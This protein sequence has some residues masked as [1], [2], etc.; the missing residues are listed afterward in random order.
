MKK[1]FF[2]T[3]IECVGAAKLCSI[4]LIIKF[5]NNDKNKRSAVDKSYFALGAVCHQFESGLPDKYVI[6]A[7]AQSGRAT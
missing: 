4:K 5:F 3:Q 2:T 7:V 6:H 1:I